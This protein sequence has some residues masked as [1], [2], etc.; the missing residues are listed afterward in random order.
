MKIEV[1]GDGC[2]RCDQFYE[3]VLEAV[4]ESGK[5]AEI[6]KEM[7]LQKISNYGVLSL[8]ALVIDGVLKVSGKVSKVEKI[9]DWI[10]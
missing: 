6:V 8:P 10:K 4:K 2:S 7:D 9:K 1:L 5:E 3:N